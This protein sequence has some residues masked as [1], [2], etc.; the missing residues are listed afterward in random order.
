MRGV[1]FAV[2]RG[3]IFALLGPN[4]AGKTMPMPMR[5]ILGIYVPGSGRIAWNG[6]GLDRATQRRTARAHTARPIEIP[7]Y[8]ET[9]ANATLPTT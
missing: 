3:S 5:M 1:R 4:G 7:A 8:A 2:D 9:M 6:R